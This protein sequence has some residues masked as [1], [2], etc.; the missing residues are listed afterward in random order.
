MPYSMRVGLEWGMTV[1][2]TLRLGGCPGIS[3]TEPN[4]GANMVENLGLGQEF[5]VNLDG[6]NSAGL[7]SSFE[8]KFAISFKYEC[9][10]KTIKVL[11]VNTIVLVVSADHITSLIVKQFFKCYLN[12]SLT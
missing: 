9:K 3:F 12:L 10:Q 6:K 7:V 5:R 2:R 4:I 1:S 11:V 8:L